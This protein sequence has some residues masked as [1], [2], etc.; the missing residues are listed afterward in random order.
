MVNIRPAVFWFPII[1]SYLFYADWPGSPSPVL[2]QSPRWG[3]MTT[4]LATTNLN[5]GWV[6]CD[7]TATWGLLAASKFYKT[8]HFIYINTFLFLSYI[9]ILVFK[10]TFKL[11][12]S[13]VSFNNIILLDWSAQSKHWISHTIQ[14]TTKY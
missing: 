4:G 13:K 14:A 11:E 12:K 7:L 1:F 8:R 9:L 6:T 3:Y 2:K 5:Q 10:W